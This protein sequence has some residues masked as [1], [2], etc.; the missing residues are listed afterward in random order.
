MLGFHYNV[1]KYVEQ[2]CMVFLVFEILNFKSAWFSLLNAGWGE[3]GRQVW[4]PQREAGEHARDEDVPG[5]AGQEDERTVGICPTFPRRRR[6]FGRRVRGVQSKFRR[7]WYAPRRAV[8]RRGPEMR[9]AVAGKI[10]DRNTCTSLDVRSGFVFCYN[11]SCAGL[12]LRYARE[13]RV[14]SY[15][16]LGKMIF[17]PFH[18]SSRYFATY[19]QLSNRLRLR[20]QEVTQLHSYT[21]CQYLKETSK[22]ISFRKT[23][24]WHPTGISRNICQR[25]L[26]GARLKRQWRWRTWS[27][28]QISQIHRL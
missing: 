21:N 14:R 12:L 1:L 27:V 19:F 6:R 3:A 24:V 23:C 10:W 11:S 25:H 4:Q 17:F 16:G 26:S 8:G 9:F 5:A 15:F 18:G 20:D 2:N 22:S 13:T 7:V 28:L